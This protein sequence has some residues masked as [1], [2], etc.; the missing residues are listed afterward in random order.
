MK[1]FTT[2]VATAVNVGLI[3]GC[4]YFVDQYIVAVADRSRGHRHINTRLELLER[5]VGEIE[6]EMEKIKAEKAGESVS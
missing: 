1:I 6:R 2:I 4:A 5:E 3:M